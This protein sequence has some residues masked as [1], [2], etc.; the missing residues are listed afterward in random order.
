MSSCLVNQTEDVLGIA[1]FFSPVE[2]MLFWSDTISN[3]FSSIGRVEIVGFE[4]TELANQL[5]NLGFQPM[6]DLIVWVKQVNSWSFD[7]TNRFYL[8]IVTKTTE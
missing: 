5:H 7:P 1:N 4:R 8:F 2:D 6:G 3:I